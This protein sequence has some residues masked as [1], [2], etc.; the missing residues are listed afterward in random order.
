[1]META[2]SPQVDY[3]TKQFVKIVHSSVDGSYLLLGE[4][5]GISSNGNH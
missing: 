1:M 2:P 3:T 4:V 5:Y